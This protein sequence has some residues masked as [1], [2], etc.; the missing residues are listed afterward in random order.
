MRRRTT[1]AAG[2]AALVLVVLA[3]CSDDPGSEEI[4]GT[5]TT[6]ATAPQPVPSVD[7]SSSGSIAIRGDWEAPA[8]QWIV[9]FEED[10]T[11][12]EDFRGMPDFR[13]G[14]YEVED[15]TVRLFGDDG[16]TDEGSLE[17]DTIV[18][19]LGTLERQ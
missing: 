11:F 13:T 16:N 12:T 8:A 1:S 2:L 7:A 19:R 10:G 4:T 18:F 15:D 14:T 5:T 6:S 3:G 9:H 17:G